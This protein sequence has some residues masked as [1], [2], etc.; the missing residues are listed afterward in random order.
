RTEPGAGAVLDYVAYG[1]PAEA[2]GKLRQHDAIVA[3][4]GQPIQTSDDLFLAL[5]TQLAGNK[6]TLDVL[7]QGGQKTRVEVTLAKLHVPGKKIVSS[8]GARP[9]FR[10]LRVDFASLLVQQGSGARYLPKGVLI[11]EIQSDSAAAAVHLKQGEI[12]SHVN[13]EAVNNPA[14]FYQA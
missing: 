4:D 7:R 13:G 3:V 11:T 10:G 12:I 2:Q 6:I 9:F 8:L 14:A 5:G 1:S